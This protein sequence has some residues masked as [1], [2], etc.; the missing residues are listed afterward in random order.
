[1]PS[2]LNV[3]M[4]TV[5]HAGS[6]GM[7]MAFPD[8]CKTPAPPAPPIPIPYPNIAQ[9]SDTADGSSTVKVDGNPIMLKSSNFSMSSGD[10]AGALN[11]VVSNKIKG[12]AQP[13]NASFDVKIDGKAVFRLTDPMTANGGS[14]CNA[15]APAEVQSPQLV[16]PFDENFCKILVEKAT[17]EAAG[18][19]AMTESGVHANHHQPMKDVCKDRSVVLYVRK[20]KKSCDPWIGKGCVPKPH[21][22]LNGSTI[23]NVKAD[24]PFWVKT[25]KFLGEL[26]KITAAI[27]HEKP[28]N[29]SL[30]KAFIKELGRDSRGLPTYENLESVSPGLDTKDFLGIIGHPATTDALAFPIF[31]PTPM[32]PKKDE[33][34]K[35]ESGPGYSDEA[36]KVYHRIVNDSGADY[37]GKWMTGDYDLFEVLSYGKGCKRV[38]GTNFDELRKALNV[39][40]KWDGI[41]HGAQ[42]H[43][44]PEEDH[45]MTEEQRKSLD[46]SSMPD[47]VDD[48]LDSYKTQKRAG[49]LTADSEK[50]LLEKK[51]TIAK[52]KDKTD[53]N[54]TTTPGQT[55][56][57]NVI[58]EDVTA[59]FGDGAVNLKSKKDL[60]E[61]LL[62]KECGD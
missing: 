39:A 21:V 22:I 57:M 41:Q 13:V 19:A 17:D 12:K 16:L 56:K 10:E 46:F 24:N 44:V 3:N 54:G 51:V 15:L 47:E 11:G 60:V 25:G 37:L 26:K 49:T 35:D 28:G 5:V 55:R 61:A 31:G 36:G 34:G 18:Q 40:M 1:M 20:T 38:T 27:R 32:E 42:V 8:V 9:S 6:S 45:G 14:A 29:S 7:A 33:S 59:V 23:D 30:V 2:T 4:M 62:C 43:W 53:A 58:D 50:G 52:E 48:I